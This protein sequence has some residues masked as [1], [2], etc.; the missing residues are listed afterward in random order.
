[1]IADTTQALGVFSIFDFNVFKVLRKGKNILAVEIIT[2]KAGD[3]TMGFVDW[4]LVPPDKNMGIWREVDLEINNSVGFKNTY[5]QSHCMTGK[6]EEDKFNKAFLEISTEL[7]NYT[8]QP[9]T[10]TFKGKV[11][12]QN[13]A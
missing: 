12:P 6:T 8:N 5:V 9:Q 4:A 3:F 11:N 2:P 1:L 7:T 10:V 13:I